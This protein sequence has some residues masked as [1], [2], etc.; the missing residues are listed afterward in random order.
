MSKCPN[1]GLNSAICLTFQF[2]SGSPMSV[3][4]N[5]WKTRFLLSFEIRFCSFVL[6][7]EQ[8]RKTFEIIEWGR[9]IFEY[10]LLSV[11]SIPWCF[12]VKAVQILCDLLYVFLSPWLNC[13]S[14]KWMSIT[15]INP[16]G[17]STAPRNILNILSNTYQKSR[18]NFLIIINNHH[19]NIFRVLTTSLFWFCS[20]HETPIDH[21]DQVDLRNKS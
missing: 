16:D 4:R 9:D 17:S 14:R 5:S 1:L 11:Q 7:T 2:G 19:Q 3:W 13:Q 18:Q 20:W 8:F 15:E 21:L 10:S 12:V 6:D